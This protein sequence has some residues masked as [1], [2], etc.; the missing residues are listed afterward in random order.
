VD[1]RLRPNGRAGFL[2]SSITAFRE[3]QLNEAWTWELQA[4]TRSRFIAG[5]RDLAAGFNRVR[6]EVLCRQRT[7][8]ELAA[9]LLEMRTKMRREHSGGK[10]PEARPSPKHQPGGLIDIEFIAQLGVLGSARQ[11]PRVIQVTGTL[12]QLNELMSIG[13]LSGKQA[14]ILSETVRRLNQH[15]MMDSLAPGESA[16][17]EETEPAAEIFACKMGESSPAL[18]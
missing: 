15:R 10:P 9:D 1:T 17:P 12:Q 8:D 5:S 16:N 14:G 6:Q 13:W 18:P 7:E 4:L 3:Y 2:V 11:F